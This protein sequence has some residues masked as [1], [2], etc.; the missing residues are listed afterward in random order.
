MQCS[1]YLKNSQKQCSRKAETGSEYCWQHKKIYE[2]K[3]N[4]IEYNIGDKV[5][6][7]L[8]PSLS[9]A[10]I[11]DLNNI[12][13]DYAY[14]EFNPIDFLNYSQLNPK[15][16]PYT[17]YLEDL[18]IYIN[19]LFDS[20]VDQIQLSYRNLNTNPSFTNFIR[21]MEI[22]KKWIAKVIDDIITIFADADLSVPIEKIISYPDRFIHDFT[23]KVHLL[24]NK[25]F[26]IIE[27]KGDGL[28]FNNDYKKY[29]NLEHF[30]KLIYIALYIYHYRSLSVIE[31]IQ[32]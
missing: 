14:S 8:S 2:Q 26:T 16:Y 24:Q 27:V 9:P 7:K 19:K 22:E 21:N 1:G 29:N 10:L 20:T 5:N 3:E 13:Y 31:K 17:Q 4:N 6:N 11:P 25:N 12:I 18:N 30:W 32:S 15:K 28:L 23:L